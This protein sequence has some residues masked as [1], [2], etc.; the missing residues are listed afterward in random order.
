MKKIAFI[1]IDNRPVCYTLAE[2]IAKIDKD[3]D[4]VMPSRDFLGGLTK[5]ANINAILNWLKNI[6]PVDSLIL[7]LDTICY[8]GLIPSRRGKET[9]EELKIRLSDIKNL[10]KEK[11]KK[12][13]AVSSIMRISNNNVNEEEKAYWSE[14]GKKIFEFSFNSGKN[15]HFVETDVPKNIIEDYLETRKRNFEVNKIYLDW[16]SDGIFEKL[17]FSKDD[18][19]E[20]GFNV[21]EAK[22][23]E[24]LIIDRNL[25]AM[26][27]TGADEIPLSLLSC[28]I[29]DMNCKNKKDCNFPKFSV[30][31]LAPEYKDKISKYEDVSIEKCV[32]GQIE[33]AGCKIDDKNP[34]LEL[35]VN[36]FEKTQGEIVMNVD[37]KHFDEAFIPPESPYLIADVRFANGADNKFVNEFFKNKIDLKNFYGYSAWNTSAN[38][39]GSL[40]CCALVKFFAKNIDENAFKKV[41]FVRFADDWAYQAN[42]RQ[43]LKHKYQN[44]Q[45]LPL[46]NEIKPFM[47]KINKVLISDFNAEFSFPW[48]RF[49]EVEVKIK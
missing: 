24:T 42:V 15:G 34:D 8:G 17:I 46:E 49:F 28:A 19:A 9:L 47:D 31:F 13:Y 39:I 27:K 22:E 44:P 18:C 48:N 23:L 7:S 2:Q 36:N 6:E 11:A 32:L 41:Q 29:V 30:K 26:V 12:V 35:I 5:I 1:P 25:P 4:L 16:A 38:S 10:L 43:S 3:I 33:L 45:I 14:Y 21:S 37:T 40:I 20:Y